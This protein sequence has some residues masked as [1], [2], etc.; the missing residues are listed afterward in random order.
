[1]RKFMRRIISRFQLAAEERCMLHRFV[2]QNH[3]FDEQNVFESYG[4]TN[5]RR[6]RSILQQVDP[7]GVFQKLQP[8]Y[9]KLGLGEEEFVKFEL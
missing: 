6:L 2:F 8:G 9:F 1:M 7:D 3:A 5:L 4:T